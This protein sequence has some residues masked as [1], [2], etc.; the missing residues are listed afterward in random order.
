MFAEIK[1]K[2]PKPMKNYLILVFMFFSVKNIAQTDFKIKFQKN[3]YDL[4]MSHYK[5]ADF[6]KA[7]DLFSIASKIKPEN[8]IGKD[9]GKKGRIP[10]N[11]C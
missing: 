10:R 9:A 7:L 5:K 1:K 8:E 4:A 6:V 3:E 2:N 11:S